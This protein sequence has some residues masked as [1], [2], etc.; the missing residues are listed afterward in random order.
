[1]KTVYDV[2]ARAIDDAI[3]ELAMEQITVVEV[4]S[5]EHY[6]GIFWRNGRWEVS[7]REIE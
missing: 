6:I 7:K 4:S 3:A 2:L 1:M 5:D